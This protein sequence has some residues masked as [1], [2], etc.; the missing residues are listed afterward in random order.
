[1]D[2][3][4]VVG[5]Q[6]VNPD[7]QRQVTALVSN[8]GRMYRS[9][10]RVGQLGR[11]SRDNRII[12][13]NP[14]HRNLH[15]LRDRYAAQLADGYSQAGIAPVLR[16]LPIYEEPADAAE[17]ISAFRL[18]P[19]PGGPIEETTRGFLIACGLPVPPAQ[20][21]RA[22]RAYNAPP[23]STRLGQTEL[24]RLVH[25]EPLHHT[26]PHVG[27]TVTADEVRISIGL[28]R[29]FLT[30]TDIRALYAALDAHLRLRST[31]HA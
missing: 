11:C 31:P 24:R 30:P 15:C 26:G 2:T 14:V 3:M 27:F 17:V 8:S 13:E 5:Y 6:L 28:A 1:M 25:G 18:D 29:G 21:S 16:T 10:G 9:S 4:T 22:A 20:R 7:T 19:P 12:G 23:P